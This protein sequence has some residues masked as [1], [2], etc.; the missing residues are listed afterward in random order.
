MSGNTKGK[1]KGKSKASGRSPKRGQSRAERAF[2]SLTADSAATRMALGGSG[3]RG[4][5]QLTTNEAPF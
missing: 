1:F 2:A 3:G 5:R 4:V